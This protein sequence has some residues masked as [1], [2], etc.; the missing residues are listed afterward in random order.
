[1]QYYSVQSVI[2]DTEHFAVF[3]EI[4][5]KNSDNEHSLVFVFQIIK[6]YFKLSDV[7]FHVGRKNIHVIALLS[8]LFLLI[9]FHL[10]NVGQFQ[11]DE[12][13]CFKIIY[14]SKVHIE[15]NR[16]FGVHKV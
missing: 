11:F 8:C 16:I 14:S 5:H 12:F 3:G 6:H 7:G 9:D 15:C 10:F 13:L 2:A 1:M 4:G